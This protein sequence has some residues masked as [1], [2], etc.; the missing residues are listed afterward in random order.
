MYYVAVVVSQV[1]SISVFRNSHFFCLCNH[2]TLICAIYE[3]KNMDSKFPQLLE[4]TA[5]DYWFRAR[6]VKIF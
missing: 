6:R 4:I 2:K 3:N 5:V 1:R